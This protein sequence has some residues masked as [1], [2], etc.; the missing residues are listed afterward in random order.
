MAAVRTPIDDAKHQDDDC[1]GTP[2]ARKAVIGPLTHAP[3]VK[4]AVVVERNARQ[5]VE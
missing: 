3:L 5:S 1:G 2:C 4:K